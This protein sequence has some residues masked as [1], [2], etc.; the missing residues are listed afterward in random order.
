M[1]MNPNEKPPFITRIEDMIVFP[2]LLGKFNEITGGVEECG[3]LLQIPLDFAPSA[4]LCPHC[5]SIMFVDSLANSE[6]YPDVDFTWIPND[7]YAIFGYATYP[8]KNP[9]RMYKIHTCIEKLTSGG[10][11]LVAGGFTPEAEVEFNLSEGQFLLMPSSLTK[12]DLNNLSVSNEKII[13][14]IMQHAWLAQRNDC[15]LEA[16]GFAQAAIAINP[17]LIWEIR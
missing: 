8:A 13:S 9:H 12:N 4:F 5:F 15:H 14:T 6:S 16:I 10:T 7:K 1:A 2:C 11:I 17:A 3:H